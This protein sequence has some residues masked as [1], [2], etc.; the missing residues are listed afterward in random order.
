LRLTRAEIINAKKPHK[1]KFMAQSNS[2]DSRNRGVSKTIKPNVVTS[3][4][5]NFRSAAILDFRKV[6]SLSYGRIALFSGGQLGKAAMHQT[7]SK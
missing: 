2:S 7:S 1:S 3:G 6:F 4:N 5:R